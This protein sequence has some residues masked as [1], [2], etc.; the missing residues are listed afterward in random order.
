MRLEIYR[1]QFIEGEK[2]VVLHGHPKHFHRKVWA[3]TEANAHYII[4]HWSGCTEE[5][6]V[7]IRVKPLKMI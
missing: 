2:I 3:S 1:E 6:P 7:P 4:C 5:K